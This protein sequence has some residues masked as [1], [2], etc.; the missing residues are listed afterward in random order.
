MG[1][2][3]QKFITNGHAYLFQD[4]GFLTLQTLLQASLFLFHPLALGDITGNTQERNRLALRIPDKGCGDLRP[5][6][7]AVFPELL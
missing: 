5:P 4:I 1:C 6:V 3:F 7:R 2:H